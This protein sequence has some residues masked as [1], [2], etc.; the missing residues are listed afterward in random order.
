VAAK[1]FVIPNR[2]FPE[3]SLPQQPLAASVLSDRDTS[4]DEQ[5]PE[6]R[7][8]PAPSGRVAG[9]VGWKRP[10]GVEVFGEDRHRND[11]ERHRV[12]YLAHRLSEQIDVVG[13]EAS[14]AVSHRGREEVSRPGDD[15]SSVMHHA[16]TIRSEADIGTAVR[17]GVARR[18]SK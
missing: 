12:P 15:G 6:A 8:D 2:V 5:I 7:L 17:E 1:I 14:V 13:E 3:A 10:Y 4:R 18:A 11:F 16:A 9:I